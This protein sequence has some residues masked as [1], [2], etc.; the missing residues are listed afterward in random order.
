MRH[1]IIIC[2]CLIYLAACGDAKI[3]ITNGSLVQM[4]DVL[5]KFPQQELFGTI[6]PGL[7]SDYHSVHKPWGTPYVEANIQGKKYTLVPDDHV[8]DKK[9]GSGKYTYTLLF[10]EGNKNRYP[11]GVSFQ[12]N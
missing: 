4:D 8:G 3:R 12:K 6:E 11:F 9:L 10:N 1:K 7:T 2:C 5:F